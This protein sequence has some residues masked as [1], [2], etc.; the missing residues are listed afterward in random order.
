MR[1]LIGISRL[2]LS[3]SV[4]RPLEDNL[5]KPSSILASCSERSELLS[6]SKSPSSGCPVPWYSDSMLTG[7]IVGE[8][9]CGLD[10]W[11]GCMVSCCVE[12]PFPIS[13]VICTLRVDDVWFS[14]FLKESE[15]ETDPHGLEDAI[16]GNRLMSSDSS[17]VQSSTTRASSLISNFSISVTSCPF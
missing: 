12:P 13:G 2:L 11:G 15:P 1:F 16:L 4:L 8:C 9:R 3:P 5:S 7:N 17:A 14:W 6:P 10:M